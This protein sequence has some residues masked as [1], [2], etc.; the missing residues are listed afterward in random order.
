MCLC[1]AALAAVWGA[2]VSGSLSADEAVRLALARNPELIALRKD[3]TVAEAYGAESKLL[4]S[5]EVR[6]A[7]SDL[8]PGLE[9][10]N[11]G[12]N[13]VGLRWSPPGVGELGLKSERAR[14]KVR[15]VSGG[16]AVAEQKLAAE[17]RLLHGTI[18][19]MGEQIRVAEE[20]V[21]V[22]ERILETVDQQVR[23]GLKN[24]LD[25][26]MAELSVADAQSAAERYRADLRVEVTRL[27]AKL[28][29]QVEAA[30]VRGDRAVLEFVPAVIHREKLL[31]SAL[32]HRMEL[33]ASDARCSQSELAVR[34]A[35]RE[36]Y[37]WFSYVQ[38]NRRFGRVE[39]PGT[40]GFQL[41]FEVPVFRWG[42]A[43]TQVAS[44]ELERCRAQRQAVKAGIVAEI[45]ELLA[46]LDAAGSGVRK[47]REALTALAESTG[48]AR[49]SLAAGQSDNL[50]V[51]L[52][53]ARRLG[54]ME[55]YV[56]KL[57]EYR[58]LEAGLGQA[59]G[60]AVR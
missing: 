23:A 48:V 8:S 50:E 60:Q 45:D 34:R 59:L 7:V 55:M 30:S 5:P 44:A 49:V 41:G 58:A 35:G 20:N 2:E 31:A 37:P 57:M 36:R 53:E 28:D 12:K 19:L 40:W 38:V 15:E 1:G 51:L 14:L 13:N 46:R 33:D 47:Q 56:A 22:R 52:T 29:L 9:S 24:S 11:Q 43:G 16:I 32:E 54:G 39:D 4:P 25:R 17:V 21:R 10:F 3:R 27:S 26:S 6:F 42:K 18:C